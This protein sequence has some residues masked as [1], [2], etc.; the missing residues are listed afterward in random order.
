MFVSA[1]FGFYLLRFL[2]DLT[3]NLILHWLG[4]IRAFGTTVGGLL[5]HAFQ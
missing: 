2:F 1:H 3:S 4:Q 5:E